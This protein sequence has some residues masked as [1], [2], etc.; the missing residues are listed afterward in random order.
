MKQIVYD[1]TK[2]NIPNLFRDWKTTR[3]YIYRE[4]E[5]ERER[6]GG[7][8]ILWILKKYQKNIIWKFQGSTEKEMEFPRLIKKTSCWISIQNVFIFGFKISKGCNRV[9][10]NLQGQ[11]FLSS[12]ISKSKLIDL[13]NS[14]VCF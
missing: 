11:S 9:S 2:V 6:G 10:R 4:R 1:T 5:R 14:V 13:K 3:G 8:E 7:M 12:R